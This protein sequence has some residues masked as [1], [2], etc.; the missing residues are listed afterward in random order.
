MFVYTY[1]CIE[2]SLE[3]YSRSRDGLLLDRKTAGWIV[4]RN[5][6]ITV[7]SFVSFEFCTTCMYFLFKITNKTNVFSKTKF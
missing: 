7:Y 1:I 4:E 2:L 3:G 5:L 6:I